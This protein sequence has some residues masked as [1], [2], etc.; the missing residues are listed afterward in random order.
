MTGQY[1]NAWPDTIV[2]GAAI[3]NNAPDYVTTIWGSPLAD[4]S[5]LDCVE[6][7]STKLV[8][9]DRIE[10]EIAVP[11]YLGCIVIEGSTEPLWV[12]TTQ[13]LP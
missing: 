11:T 10:H 5:V 13:P 8:F 12:N 7:S 4:R 6:R 1:L 2:A 9:R 3:S